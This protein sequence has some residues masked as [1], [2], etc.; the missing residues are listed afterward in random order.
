MNHIEEYKQRN[1]KACQSIQLEILKT[2]T[3]ICD[4]HNFTYWLD[5]GTLLGAIRHGGFIPWDDDIDIIMPMADYKKF[6]EI[7]QREFP[8]N[9]FLQTPEN[10]P[11]M[12]FLFSKVRRTDSLYV[13]FSDDFTQP[14]NKGIYIDIFPFD[15]Y[16]TRILPLTRKVA[17]YWAKSTGILRYKKPLGW[18]SCAEFLF[19][20]ITK[21]AM[22]MLW[23]LILAMGGKGEYIGCY[24][25]NTN[26]HGYMHRIK[27]VYPLKEILFEGVPFACPNDTDAYLKEYYNDYMQIPSEEDRMIHASFFTSKEMKWE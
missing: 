14:Y 15:D 23:K 11:T 24:P 9:L 20:S 25:V 19:F 22:S 12:P 1:L 8:D 16:P 7:A 17:D 2:V 6:L 18:R 3:A 10:E 4:K 21:F 27:T 26:R 5:G 13:E